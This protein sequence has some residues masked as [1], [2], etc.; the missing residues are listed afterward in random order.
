GGRCSVIFLGRLKRFVQE[1]GEL[2]LGHGADLGCG[3]LAVFEEHQSRDTADA[4]LGGRVGIF[5][6]VELRND[7]TALV[8]V[9]SLIEDGRDHFA[10]AT[11][12][13]PVI[14]QYGKVGLQYVGVER[15]VRNMLN[16]ITHGRKRI[17]NAKLLRALRLCREADAS[18]CGRGNGRWSCFFASIPLAM[19]RRTTRLARYP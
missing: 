8:L 9:S 2:G 18:E 13:G 15:G 14:N 5:V 19:A 7:N 10:R 6:D 1:S 12:L 17:E 4:E 3:S 16:G 11:P